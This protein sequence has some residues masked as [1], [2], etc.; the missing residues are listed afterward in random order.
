MCMIISIVHKGLRMYYE[1]G[2]GSK[3]PSLQLNK[4]RRILDILDAVS[5]EVDIK[6]MGLGIHEL[7]GKFSGFW[8]VSVT[9][10]YRIIFRFHGGDIYDVDYLDYH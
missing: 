1:E 6:G 4:L 9:G 3:L 5:S 2:K 10:N 7:K 8:A